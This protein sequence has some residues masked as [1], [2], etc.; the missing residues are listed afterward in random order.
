MVARGRGSLGRAIRK[1]SE[2][3]EMFCILMGEGLH[4]CVFFIKTQGIVHFKIC[5]FHCMEI[6]P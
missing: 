1:F 4:G 6:L 2:G 5:E 3:L